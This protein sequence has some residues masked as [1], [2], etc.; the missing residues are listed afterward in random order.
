MGVRC[1][2]GRGQHAAEGDGEEECQDNKLGSLHLT[3]KIDILSYQLEL[4]SAV[5]LFELIFKMKHQQ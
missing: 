1:W 2:V 4:F 5:E 3:S